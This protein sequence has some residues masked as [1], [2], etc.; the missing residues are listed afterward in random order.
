MKR[1]F[2]CQRVLPVIEFY[3]HPQMAD[4]HLGKCKDCTR[5]DV[6]TARA[7]SPEHYRQY[8]ARRNRDPQ[9][10]ARNVERQRER[11]RISPVKARAR[12]MVSNAVRDGRLIPLPCESCGAKA[13]AHHPDYSKPLEVR[14]LCFAHHRALH[15]ALRKAA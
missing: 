10:R 12:R 11:N 7:A 8:D 15:T 4:G 6:A 5:R 13:E 14:W 2:K 9:R 3:R 1:C